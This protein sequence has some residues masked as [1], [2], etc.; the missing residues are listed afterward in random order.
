VVTLPTKQTKLR[1]VV[2]HRTERDTMIRALACSADPNDAR[3]VL[4]Q[5]SDHLG[6]DVWV[7]ASA[8]DSVGPNGMPAFHSTLIAISARLAAGRD[9]AEAG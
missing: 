2:V 3:G 5:E 4:W 8:L 7:A 9:F 6:N 1:G